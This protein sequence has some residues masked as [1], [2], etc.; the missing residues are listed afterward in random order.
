MSVGDFV[1]RFL[2]ARLTDR[3]NAIPFGR[4]LARGAFWTLF[5]TLATR[6]VRIP[7]SVILARL[8]GAAE[9]GELGMTM[10]SID[11]FMVFAG[12]GLGLTAT[13]YIAEHRTRDPIRAGR[14]IAVSTVVATISGAIFAVVMF[15]IAPWLADHTL[16][17]HTL[18]VPLRIGA[19]ALFFSSV[20]GA[21]TGALYGFEAFRSAA[22]LQAIT[23]LLDFPFMLGGF[24]LGGLDGVMWGIAISRFTA[25][26][27]IGSALRTETRRHGIHVVLSHWK[28]ELEVLWHFSI[29]AALAGV[30]VM[31]V[32]WICSTLLVNQPQGYASMG[33][34]SAANQ[35][36]NSVIFLPTTLGAALLP[37]LSDRMGQKDGR[38]SGGILRVMMKINA[39]IVIPAALVISILSPWI[40]RL[41]GSSYANSASTLVA[42]VL[43][44]AIMGII[45][46]V[47]DVIAASGRMWMGFLMNTGWAVVYIA[48]TLLLIHLGAL[49]LASSRLIAYTAHA[50]WTAAFAWM[51]IRTHRASQQAIG[52]NA[53]LQAEASAL[54]ETHL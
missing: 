41:Y 49:G 36:Y 19:V 9:Y 47:G 12:F 30:L 32:N 16:S 29:P 24:F 52:A 2:P 5:G 45:S 46:P 31:P 42:V 54:T 21:Q 4:R 44:A 28:Q 26:M 50:I 7:I 3:I 34:Y 40:M 35:W 1:L 8:M 11:L 23:G 14:I 20:N 18:I 43:T 6:V 22:W 33:I 25:W 13:K 39:A 51:V 37:I 17:N 15:L 27:L 48:S 53:A 38:S 10:G